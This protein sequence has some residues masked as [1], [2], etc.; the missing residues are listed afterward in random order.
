M[1]YLFSL[2]IHSKEETIEKNMEI[3]Y[4]IL[5]NDEKKII[6]NLVNNKG[7]LAQFKISGKLGKVKSHRV[8]KKLEEKGI[9]NIEKRGKNNIIRLTKNLQK[10]L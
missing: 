9:I 5:D 2:K 8:V 3:L 4:K 10:S 7:R 1:Y 6:K